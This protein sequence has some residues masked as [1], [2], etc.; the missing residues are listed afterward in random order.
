MAKAK[1]KTSGAGQGKPWEPFDKKAKPTNVFNLRFNDYYMA[2]LRHAA[3]QDEDLSMHKICMRILKRELERLAE[4]NQAE[5]E[6]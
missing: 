1:A 3:D 5:G 2:I 6:D 4:T